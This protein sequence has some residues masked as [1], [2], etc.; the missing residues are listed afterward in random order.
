MSKPYVFITR[1]ISEEVLTP[2]NQIADVQ[3]WN[4]ESEAVPREV[5]LQEGK[6]ADALLTM[7]SDSVDEELLNV[8]SNLKV[9]AN[10]AV[11][12][13]N[14]DLETAARNDV[15]VCNTPDV[16]TETTADLAFGLMLSAARRLA[17]AH[18]FVKEGQ[19]QSWSPYL[20]AGADVHHKTIGIVGMGSIGTAVAR[21]AKGFGMEI[22]YHNRSRHDEAEKELGAVYKS[23]DELLELSDFVVCL[24]PLTEETK[25]LFDEDAFKRMKASAIFINVGRGQVVDEGALI[26]ALEQKEI[27]GAGLD[28]FYKEP[29]GADHPLLKFPQVVALPHI[30]SASVETRTTMMELCRDNIIAVLE[31]RAAKSVV[32][33]K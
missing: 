31:G 20:L 8:A 32:G 1:K 22:L 4:S 26:H 19:W 9:V 18:L 23:F 27:A 28:V 24:T 25:N 11:G 33:R 15:I 16:L 5:L 3:M 21:R 7:L 30:G 13:D 29:I 6:K 14:I 2:L 12:Y 10:L 17:E